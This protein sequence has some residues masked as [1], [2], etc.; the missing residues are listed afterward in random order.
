MEVAAELENLERERLDV[1]ELATG[2]VQWAGWKCRPV[3]GQEDA[4]VLG[5][6]IRVRRLEAKIERLK[7]HKH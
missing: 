6:M 5:L 4:M 1:L 7:R 2:I 3:T